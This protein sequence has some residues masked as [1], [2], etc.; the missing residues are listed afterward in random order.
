M[1]LIERIEEA[2]ENK[3]TNA[4]ALLLADWDNNRLTNQERNKGMKEFFSITEKKYVFEV[5]DL[6]TIITILNVL[7][8]VCGFAWAPWLGIVNCSVWL[9][10]NVK[11]R[12]HVNSYVTQIALI[13]L[14]IYFLIL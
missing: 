12:A 7:F 11:A 2:I 6:T 13:I 14:N 3:D 5:A 1:S 9:V 4:L 10:L 8:V